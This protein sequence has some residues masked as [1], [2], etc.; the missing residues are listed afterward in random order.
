MSIKPLIVGDARLSKSG[1]N[2]RNHR[3]FSSQRKVVRFKKPYRLL[4]MEN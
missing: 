1:S 2:E 4:E 3:P